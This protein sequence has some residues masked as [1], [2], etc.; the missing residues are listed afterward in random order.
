M[1][2]SYFN[3][4]GG[5]QGINASYAIT[6]INPIIAKDY[7]F[8]LHENFI[9][10]VIKEELD[11]KNILLTGTE[12]CV[13][14]IG[15]EGNHMYSVRSVEEDYKNKIKIIELDNP[16]GIN[17]KMESF[18][19][20]L[21]SKYSYIEEDLKKFNLENKNNGKLKILIENLKQDF[22]Y[23]EIVEFDEIKKDVKNILDY[24]P[25]PKEPSGRHQPPKIKGGKKRKGFLDILGIDLQS[26]NKFFEKYKYDI[27]KGIYELTEMFN[28]YGTKKDVFYE[29]MGIHNS[30]GFF[31]MFNPM[32]IYYKYYGY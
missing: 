30:G 18:S 19:L 15:I 26:Q 10:K 7:F 12:E 2:G 27:D 1:N 16:W 4:N 29:F 8:R 22:D 28:K 5:Y 11:A 3:I 24:C 14:L 25:P 6:G 32:N 9:Y 21:E 13:D 17:D 31:S 20:N 23:I